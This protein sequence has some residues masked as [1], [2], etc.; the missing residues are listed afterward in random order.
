MPGVADERAAIPVSLMH[1]PLHFGRNVSWT[2][3]RALRTTRC[4][5]GG[6]LL[7]LE[8][9]D[10]QAQRVLERIGYLGAR[11]KQL[12]GSRQIV[13]GLTIDGGLKPEALG[14]ERNDPGRRHRRNDCPDTIRSL[15]AC[16]QIGLIPRN[17]KN[18]PRGQFDRHTWLHWRLRWRDGSR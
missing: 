15:R 9:Q 12:T 11:S 1:A 5:Y 10:Q 7:L 17:V 16:F 2:P 8:L 3:A 4:R 14:C 13:L 18:W 6:E